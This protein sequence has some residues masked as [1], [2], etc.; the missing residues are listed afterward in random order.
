MRDQEW[1]PGLAVAQ[2]RVA[3][4][5]DRLAEVVEFYSGC[6]G[7]PELYRFTGHAGY[8]GVMLGL[9]GT[10]YHLEFTSHAEGSPGPAPTQEN[11]LVL[12]FDGDTRMQETVVRLGEAGHEPVELENPYWA[13]NG[14]LA[15]PD[16][17]GWLVVLVPRPVF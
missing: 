16:P 12:Y 2:V 15:F 9:P 1:P 11:L 5:T 13:E 17:D 4:P 10:D 14:A 3:R 8:D 6:L 7:L